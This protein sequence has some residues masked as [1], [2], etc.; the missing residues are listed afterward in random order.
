MKLYGREWT[1]RELESR[2]GRI[3]QIGGIRQFV[4][5]EGREN[6]VEQIQIRT[7]AGL[8]FFVVPSR[9]LDISLAEFAGTPVSWQSSNGDVNPSFYD[10]RGSEWLKTAAGGLL[11]TCGLSN[12]G[13][14]VELNGEHYGLHGRAHHTPAQQVCAESFWRD[15]EYEII[16][17]GVIEETEIFGVF[18]RRTRVIRCKLGENSIEIRDTVENCGFQP[19]VC[20]ILYH[21]NFGFPLMTEETDIVFSSS[22]VKPRDDSTPFDNYDIWEIPQFDFREQVYYHELNPNIEKSNVI[23]HNPN[24]FS[25]GKTADLKVILSWETISLPYLVEWKMCGAGVHV[26]AVEPANCLVEGRNRETERDTFSLLQ[27]GESRDFKIKL[28][29]DSDCY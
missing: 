27:P 8:C 28:E 20:L 26:L 2:I 22:N 24:F 3:E 16:V 29:F 15:N 19:A 13:T 25:G 4:C 6:G 12:V 23:L 1:R 21:F 14:E 5:N 7:G 18:L 9:G 17:R 11:M 10:S